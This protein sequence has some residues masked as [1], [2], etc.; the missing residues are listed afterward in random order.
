MYR[1]DAIEWH[2][3]IQWKKIIQWLVYKHGRVSQYEVIII[4]SFGNLAIVGSSGRKLHIVFLPL[5]YENV[6]KGYIHRRHSFES[7]LSLK[8]HQATAALEREGRSVCAAT[9]GSTPS[10]QL[11]AVRD[12]IRNWS[13]K[14]ATT[15]QTCGT[16]NQRCK[17]Q[18]VS[19]NIPAARPS[20]T[21]SENRSESAWIYLLWNVIGVNVA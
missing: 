16:S 9:D 19:W 5:S 7:R 4:S 11:L 14:Q 12:P 21:F 20:R 13:A 10:R 1:R 2:L 6:K 3:F 18:T 17:P 15:S 8:I